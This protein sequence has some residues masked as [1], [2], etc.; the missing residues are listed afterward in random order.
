[1]ATELEEK[2][3]TEVKEEVEQMKTKIHFA[4]NQDS[5]C[6]LQGKNVEIS[7][8]S[9][10]Y[11]EEIAQILVREYEKTELS[12]NVKVKKRDGADNK[13]D[14]FLDFNLKEDYVERVLKNEI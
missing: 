9:Q 12:L 6:L 11:H 1:M 2:L 3:K 8:G 5:S 13:T 14:Y 10:Q 7:V 4:L